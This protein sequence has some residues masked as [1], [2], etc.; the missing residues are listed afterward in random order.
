MPLDPPLAVL[1]VFTPATPTAPVA[2]KPVFSPATPAAP[3]ASN[4]TQ[5]A[6]SPEAPDIVMPLSIAKA[7]VVGGE[8]KYPS[9]PWVWA[10]LLYAGLESGR[11]A[12]Y[13]T[14]VIGDDPQYVIWNGGYW[15]LMAASGLEWIS[16]A[17]VATPDL[18]PA[19]DY[20]A[21]ENPYAWQPGSSVKGTPVVTILPVP[22]LPV[23]P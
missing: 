9:D 3:A 20:D 21:E 12:Y 23:Q 6:M 4:P 17:D 18:V 19:G 22:P 15:S 11:K 5:G 1:P 14:G 8:S 7:R 13:Q 2:I 16:Y 10:D